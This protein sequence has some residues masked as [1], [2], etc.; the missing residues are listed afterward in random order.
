INPPDSVSNVYRA[1]SSA[2]PSGRTICQSAPPGTTRPRSPGPSNAP[3]VI[4]T[5][6]RSPAGARPISCTGPTVTCASI[7]NCS[8]GASDMEESGANR[9][10]QQP[11]KFILPKRRTDDKL[12]PRAVRERDRLPSIGHRHSNPDAHGTFRVAYR[13]DDPGNHRANLLADHE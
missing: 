9:R 10:A 5:I 8:W 6:R 1:S 11:G 7:T 4:G 2:A 12:L 13:A 3:P